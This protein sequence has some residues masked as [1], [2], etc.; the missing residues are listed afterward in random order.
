MRSIQKKYSKLKKKLNDE[1]AEKKKQEKLQN[2]VREEIA[3]SK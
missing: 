3:I 1:L 2:L